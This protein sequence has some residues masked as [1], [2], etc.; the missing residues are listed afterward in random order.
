MLNNYIIR[1]NKKYEIIGNMNYEI[2]WNNN[3]KL[4]EIRNNTNTK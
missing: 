3:M 2:I 4:Y 1:N